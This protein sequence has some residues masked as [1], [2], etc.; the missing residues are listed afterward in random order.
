MKN[1]PRCGYA[2]SEQNPEIVRNLCEGLKK[3]TPV[4]VLSRVRR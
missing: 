2:R 1:Y 4:L 3:C